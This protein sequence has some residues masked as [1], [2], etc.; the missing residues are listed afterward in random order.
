MRPYPARLLGNIAVLLSA[1]V[2]ASAQTW[3]LD[4]TF[5]PDL[6]Y[7]GDA[8]LSLSGAP[9]ADGRV[10]VFGNF[11]HANS[12]ATGGLARLRADGSV[13]PNFALAL[14]PGETVTAVA[15]LPD[16]RMLAVLWSYASTIRSQLVRLGTD[17]SK[18][19]AFAPVPFD[20]DP[21]LTVLADG[22]V[23]AWG[24]FQTVGGVARN[25]LARFNAD[26]TLEL[27]YAPALTTA[28][29]NVSAVALAPDGTVVLTGT[30]YV[31]NGSA[32]FVFTRLLASGVVD[33]RFAP[34]SVGT[35]YN[36][37][38]VQPDGSVLVG[39]GDLARYTPTGALDPTYAAQIPQLQYVLRI[40]PLPGG[41]LAVEARVGSINTIGAPAVFILGA[42]GRLERDLRQASG[43][44]EGQHLLTTLTDG[45]VL[46]AQ[47]TLVL[48]EPIYLTPIETAGPTAS[49]S[50][51]IM[52]VGGT[53][54]ANP[55][56]ALSSVDASV[57]TPVPTA[58]IQRFPGSIGRLEI[59]AAGRVLAAGT[60]T[61]IDGQPRAGL[62]RFLANG[63][64][65]SGYTPSGGG[66]FLAVPSDGRALVRRTTIGPA[67]DDGYHRYQTQIV[68][69]HLDGSVDAGFAFPASLDTASTNWLAA[70]PDGRML[71]AAF[72]PD[73]TQEQ[74]LKLI[75][76]GSDGRRGA[77]LP[78]VFT[79]FTRFNVSI[80]YANGA[81]VPVDQITVSYSGGAGLPNVLDAAQL[82]AGN[83]L[84]VAG[85]FSSVSG[86]ARPGLVR[87]L[88]DG[89]ID[90][91][92]VP[93]FDTETY[94]GSRLPLPDGRALV[95][96]SS[97]IGGFVATASDSTTLSLSH[98]SALRLRTDGSIDP[99]FTPSPDT[100]P[101]RSRRLADGSFFGNGRHFSSDG[102]PDL[103]FTPQ[104]RSGTGAGNASYAVLTADGRL[105]VGENFD[106]VNGQP[107]SSLARFAPVEVIGI[108]VPPQSQTV[109]AG[110][111]AYF[112]VALGT[113][114][115]ATY[116]WLFNGAPLAGAT[117]ATLVLSNV[118]L[119]QA[120]N[121]AVRVVVDG[122]TFTSDAAT[123][124]VTPSTARLVS[125]SARSRVTPGNPQIAG[126]VTTSASPRRRSPFP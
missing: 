21:Q 71:I 1:V 33:S 17:G 116:Q 59:D 23:L 64:L 2:C 53:T 122:Q 124:T 102:W 5:A 50:S 98:S 111:N 118:S 46:I 20:D 52:P 67:G 120:G 38:A 76:L 28:V 30:S 47:G 54:L 79:G 15:P 104:F 31:P 109:V 66:T 45:R 112:Q 35:P 70:A 14:A 85:A 121:Y 100:I 18:D 22:R 25:G 8:T 94:S 72:D 106:Q 83:Q 26:G 125:F 117:G 86:V 13:D 80:E 87:L 113:S 65:D 91:S 40:A 63:T 73:G 126:L 34:G 7:D 88:S 107:R 75:W 103:N 62:A 24:S 49:S 37:L 12:V 74:N 27:T 39:S 114:H 93:N 101:E 36:L 41:R 29:L 110:R 10:W 61:Q 68:R 56:L 108:S 105:W 58:F 81:A 119:T 115:P 78:T 43:A 60:F 48:Y 9:T 92:Y 19:P 90:T 123:L 89:S 95:L 16:G 51:V 82:L 99:T 44:R 69:L 11:T 4:P 97:Y 57:L 6:I 32:V 77:T 3:Q 84:L 55:A 42:N 96:G